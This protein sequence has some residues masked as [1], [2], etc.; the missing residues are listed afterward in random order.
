MRLSQKPRVSQRV[1][2]VKVTVA[3][4]AVISII[5]AW[6]FFFG[7]MTSSKESKA[8]GVTIAAGSTV[9][10][11]SNPYSSLSSGDSIFVYG[12]FKIKSIYTTLSS[13][14]IHLIVDGS[15]AEL[16]VFKD[17]ELHLGSGSSIT[18][19]NGG[20]LTATGGCQ[21]SSK[22]YFGSAEVANCPGSGSS[23]A[24]SFANINSAGGIGTSGAMLPVSWLNCRV[25]ERGE[26]QIQISWSTAM[27]ENNSRFVIEFSENALDWQEVSTIKTKAENGNSNGILNYTGVHYPPMNAEHCMYR[28]KQIDFDGQFDYSK[29]MLLERVLKEKVVIGTLGNSRINLKIDSDFGNNSQVQIFN[30]SGALVVSEMVEEEKNFT[31]PE[32]GVYIIVVTNGSNIERIKHLVR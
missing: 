30:T 17:K 13:K 18:L 15:G 8:A 5:A 12:K 20:T 22:I 27:E 4:V 6:V 3:G 24:N 9:N 32:P 26:D 21:S 28:I 23:G 29:V 11:T 16:K 10:S 14:S 2:L 31:L 25:A 7:G 19:L 1:D